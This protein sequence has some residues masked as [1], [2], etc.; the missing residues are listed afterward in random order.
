LYRKYDQIEFDTLRGMNGYVGRQMSVIFPSSNKG[1]YPDLQPYHG[2]LPKELVAFN[3]MSRVETPGGT[4]VHFYICDNKFESIWNYPARAMT[5]FLDKDITTLVSPDFSMHRD[6]PVAVQRWNYY[7]NLW[8]AALWQAEGF[9]VIPNVC[10]SD[11]SS[12]KWCFQGMPKESVLSVSSVGSV[13]YPEAR[14]LF[15]EG[16]KE[17]LRRL[18]PTQVMMYGRIPR[19]LVGVGPPITSYRDKWQRYYEEGTSM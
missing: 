11:P 15:V 18:R 8:C 19:E 12:Y 10:W 2:E 1:G 7:R 14:K 3:Q 17:M 16:Y 9:N 13:K 5:R 6:W 4:A